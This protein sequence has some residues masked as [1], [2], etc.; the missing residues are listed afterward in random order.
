[1]EIDPL[2]SIQKNYQDLSQQ[3]IENMA[4]SLKKNCDKIHA[5][6]VTKIY[7]SFHF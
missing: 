2:L 3:E 6:Y 5:Y 7:Q 4:Y 1:M